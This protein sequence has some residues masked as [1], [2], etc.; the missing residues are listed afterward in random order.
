MTACNACIK[1]LYYQNNVE[2]VL[3]YLLHVLNC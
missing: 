2:N 3:N 1:Y